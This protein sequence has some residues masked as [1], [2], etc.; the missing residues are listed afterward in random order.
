MSPFELLFGE[1]CRI[2]ISSLSSIPPAVLKAL[3]T[4]EDLDEAYGGQDPPVVEE[5]VLL[6]EE[7]TTSTANGGDTDGERQDLQANIDDGMA[8]DD[9]GAGESQVFK[10]ASERMQGI[11]RLRSLGLRMQKRSAQAMT[12][13]TLKKKKCEDLEVG[14]NVLIHVSE[15][16]RGKS[17]SRNLIG[18]VSQIADR[19]HGG[20]VVRT[21]HG[22][23]DGVFFPNQYVV[24]PEEHLGLDEAA[25]EPRLSVRAAAKLE[26]IVGG[27]GMMR[28]ECGSNVK[29]QTQ[30][31]KC[32]KAGVL[33]NSRCHNSNPCENK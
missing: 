13:Q 1:P 18:V 15:Y 12:D 20:V 3:K 17:D 4:E 2:G 6:N 33:C 30:K 21:R 10:L 9:Y 5:L 28:C 26:S 31:C 29:C 19:E 16:D 27:Q 14:K 7:W 22:S 8:V 23:L 32:F 25:A 11:E 24:A